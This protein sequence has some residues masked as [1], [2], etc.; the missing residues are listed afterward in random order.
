MIEE[1]T[2]EIITYDS[3]EDYYH[4]ALGIAHGAIGNIDYLIG[5]E[6]FDTDKKLELIQEFIKDYRN[7]RR[8]LPRP[9]H[10]KND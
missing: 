3:R 1:E 8:E 6:D 7:R 9:P 4:D 10:N 5:N 2:K